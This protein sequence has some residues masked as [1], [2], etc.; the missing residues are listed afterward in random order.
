MMVETR[1]VKKAVMLVA[2][3]DSLTVVMMVFPRAVLL[4]VLR[5]ELMAVHSVSM[6][7]AQLEHSRAALMEKSLVV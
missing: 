4:V 6:T 7:V 2:Q 1:A 5:A 3:L